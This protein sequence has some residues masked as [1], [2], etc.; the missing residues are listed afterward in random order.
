[1]ATTKSIKTRIQNKYDELGSWKAAGGKLLK[2]EIAIVQVP[3]GDTYINPI[4]NV[5]EPR[6]ELLMKVGDG[7]KTFEE[8]PWLSAKAAD[9]SEWAK[10]RTAEEA[11]VSIKK[12]TAVTA[13]SA[14]LGTWLKDVY[15]TGAENAAAIT[16]IDQVL[17]ELTGSGS[18]TTSGSI[19]STIQAALEALD[20]VDVD[21]ASN[22]IVKAVAQADGKV[23]VTYGSITEAELPNISSSKIIVDSSKNTTLAAKLAEIDGK[24]TGYDTQLSGVT[25]VTGSITA[26]INNLEVSEPSASGTST[27]FIATAKQENGKIVVTKKN[28]PE[29]SSST[30]GIVKL[31]ASGGA[32][33]YDAVFGTSG[34]SAQVAKNAADILG[35]ETAIAGGVHF[36]GVT[37]TDVGSNKSSASVVIDSKTITA[38]TGDVVIYDTREFIWTKDY[39]EELG[40]V[41]RIGQLQTQINNLD[42]TDTNAV[43]TTH[44]F[45]SQVTQTDGKI[46][47]IY[48]QPTSTDISH[49][50]NGTVGG[51]LSAQSGRITGVENKLDG[52]T[53][54]VSSFVTSKI[55]DLDY[56]APSTSGNTS[57]YQ[58]ISSVSQADGKIS[59]T[60]HTIPNATTSLKGVVQ[61][62]SATDSASETTAA[63]SKAVKLAYEKAAQA[64]SDF[65]NVQ[66][67]YV[68]FATADGVT[69][70]Y[71]GA[72]D[73]VIIFDCGNADD[74]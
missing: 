39:W 40:D 62:S 50:T 6:V 1:M 27:S 41:T 56:T 11:P 69:K 51:E 68:R 26:A 2:G 23:T 61:L 12:G 25:T 5:A 60:K 4:T 7:I 48:T 20:H 8:L 64:A 33:G 66:T 31:G 59:A 3:T 17:G 70:M 34:L 45:V 18:G 72:E 43:A 14:P 71:A 65:V 19:S 37:T 28:L 32:A 73:T 46:S 54:T 49:T 58:F 29:A 13:T 47:V 24:F 55:A 21:K 30:A 63:T 16:R 42:V 38:S 10:K 53:N 57:D 9:V 44:K 52:I 67:N 35:I 74:L 22:T 36:I 15:D